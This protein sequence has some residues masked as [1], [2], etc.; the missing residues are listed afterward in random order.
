MCAGSACVLTTSARKAHW[1]IPQKEPNPACGIFLTFQKWGLSG[2]GQRNRGEC[3][4]S[5]GQLKSPLGH[6]FS[7]L[8]LVSI[9]LYL[10]PENVLTS[11]CLSHVS[12][13]K[14]TNKQKSWYLLPCL[15]I[16]YTG[17][18]L[19]DSKLSHLDKHEDT[20]QKKWFF[21]NIEHWLIK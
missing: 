16:I 5:Y 11:S 3:L 18:F 10:F 8:F 15:L 2:A 12:S 7:H 6:L 21:K 19:V 1:F 20:G 14:Q 4:S 9:C 17:K 13:Q